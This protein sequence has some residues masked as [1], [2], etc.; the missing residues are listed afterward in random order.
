MT[1]GINL[2]TSGYGKYCNYS[3]ILFIFIRLAVQ[4][5]GSTKKSERE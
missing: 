2:V 5:F 1:F 4:E 3:I